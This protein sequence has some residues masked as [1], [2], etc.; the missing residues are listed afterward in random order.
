ME[1][2][3]ILIIALSLNNGRTFFFESISTPGKLHVVFLATFLEVFF[4]CLLSR[5]ETER[6]A[7][8]AHLFVLKTALLLVFLNFQC[9][10]H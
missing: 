3:V 8:V 1:R 10:N 4:Y 2:T 7:K 9:F 6:W 5:P